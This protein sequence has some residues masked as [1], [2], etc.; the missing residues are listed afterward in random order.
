VPLPDQNEVLQWAGTKTATVP[1]YM[2]IWSVKVSSTIMANH[3]D[4][5]NPRI[6]KLIGELFRDAFEQADARHYS[7]AR[8]FEQSRQKSKPPNGSPTSDESVSIPR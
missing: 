4:I 5:W 1:Q 8:Q 6:V 7:K 2:P 3:D